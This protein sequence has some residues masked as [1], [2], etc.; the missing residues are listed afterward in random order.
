MSELSPETRDLIARGRK[1][2]P[3]SPRRRAAIHAAILAEAATIA[4][5]VA[6]AT[7]ASFTTKIAVIVSVAIVGTAGTVAV[8][9]KSD[10]APQEARVALAPPTSVT[11][12][13]SFSAVV[14]PPPA[15]VAVPEPVVAAPREPPP[16]LPIEPPRAM[17]PPRDPPVIKADPPPVIVAPIA[18]T[19]PS[20]P[21][22]TP[23]ARSSLEDDANLL[24]EAHRALAA[25]DVDR[26]LRLLDEHEKRFPSSALEP[27]RSAE[28]VFALCQAKRVAEAR[29]SADAFLG[30]HGD[31][32]LAARVRAS[33]GKTAP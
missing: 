33:C 11:P 9:K 5:P 22:S 26:S 19:P 6:A 25:G 7:W 12:S 18:V 16:A 21:P 2:T 10:P 30:R 1:G 3:S 28:R 14:D 27:E 29:S 17:P 8:L 20:M 24:R 23:P 13:A 31:G 4:T 15:P 32:P